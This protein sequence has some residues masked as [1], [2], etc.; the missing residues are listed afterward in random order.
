MVEAYLF[1]V[2]AIIERTKVPFK[3]VSEPFHALVGEEYVVIENE[4]GS[5]ML[6]RNDGSKLSIPRKFLK[7]RHFKLVQPA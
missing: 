3:A 1:G 7:L 6:E 4:K 2:G 5:M